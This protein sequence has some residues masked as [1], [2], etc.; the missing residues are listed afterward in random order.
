MQIREPSDDER[1]LLSFI[2]R[3]KQ[4]KE[5]GTHVDTTLFRGKKGIVS[6]SVRVWGEKSAKKGTHY[7][8]LTVRARR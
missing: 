8:I 3:V 1:L 7:Q 4:N 2:E 5:V 6:W